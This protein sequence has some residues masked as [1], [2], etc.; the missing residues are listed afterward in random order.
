MVNEQQT[1]PAGFGPGKVL[2][3]ARIDMK[4]SPEDVALQLHLAPR[5]IEALESDDFEHLPQATYVRGYLRNYALLLGL[6]PQPILDAYA[7][8]LPHAAAPVSLTVNRE[9]ANTKDHHMKW[10]GFGV[11]A[12]VIG[13]A[14]A[15]WQDREANPGGSG[16]QQE[17]VAALVSAAPAGDAR[18]PAEN[19]SPPPDAQSAASPPESPIAAVTPPVQ[20]DAPVPKGRTRIVLRAE[21]D[22]WV[23]VRDAEQTRLVYQTIPAGKTVVAEGK[24]PLN[25]FLGNVDGV[26][27]EANGRP[28]NAA[29]Y[30]RGTIAR[31][32]VSQSEETPAATPAATVA[33]NRNA[34]AMRPQAHTVPAVAPAAKAAGETAKVVAP[35]H[36]VPTVPTKLIKSAPAPTK[37][38]KSAPAP[39][40][41]NPAAP[42]ADLSSPPPATSGGVATTTDNAMPPVT[43]ATPAPSAP[44]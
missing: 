23:E 10:I 17:D 6:A 36:T 31:F 34:H 28:F 21:Q 33:P 14:V 35:T 25:V 13:F 26:K 7:R 32:Q 1:V 24:A 41:N 43:P 20:P 16:R 37:L 27:V 2:R 22:S 19:A 38:I 11:L 30:K 29:R 3:Q 8:M 40:D 44:Q 5:Q 4:L 39:S 42:A 12:L 15:W 18:A 9:E